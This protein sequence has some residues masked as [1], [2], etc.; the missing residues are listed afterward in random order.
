[1]SDPRNFVT[2]TAAGLVLGFGLF[3]GVASASAAPLS[4][5]GLASP[6]LQVED[7]GYRRARRYQQLYAAED[8]VPNGNYGYVYPGYRPNMPFHGSIEI[9]ELQRMF[10]ETNW[11]PSMR[12]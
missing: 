5:T 4:G 3:A 2:L 6:G 9:Q 7:A 1:M 8:A 11:P 10:P 12:Y